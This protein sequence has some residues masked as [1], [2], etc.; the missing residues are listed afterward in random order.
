MLNYYKKILGYPN[1][2]LFINKYL[3]DPYLKRL[4]N[5]GYF[6]GMD[7]ASKD[8]YDFSEYI[9]R[10]DHSLTVALL[11]YKLTKNKTM[12][13]AGLY[14]DIAT[15]CFSHVID[16]MNKDYINQES[17]EDM[18]RSILEKDSYLQRLLKED[19][20][21]LEDIINYKDLSVVDN[22]RPKL[23]ADRL[24]AIILN[25]MGWIKNI[26]EEDIK[27]IIDNLTVYFNEEEQL[28]MGFKDI[29]VA[30]KAVYYNDVINNAMHSKEDIYMMQLL[31]DIVRYALN[32]N[33]I[34][35][36]DLY[37]KSETELINDLNEIDD[38]F[39]KDSLYKFENITKEEIPNDG[40]V[41]VKDRNLKPLVRSRRLG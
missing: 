32:R 35:I 38:E 37:V 21:R 10:Y 40:L 7:Y 24:D 29:K 30:Q 26:T 27:E 8:I 11:T 36:T 28:E 6:C 2:Q 39:I 20:I 25:S 4:K 17:T 41:E 23:C 9:S 3:S 13:I 15:P 18:T 31:A 19:N 34:N 33:Y 22:N 12:T 1:D 16:Y 5:I 14:H